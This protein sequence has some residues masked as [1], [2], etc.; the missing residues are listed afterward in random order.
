MLTNKKIERALTKGYGI[1]NVHTMCL[2]CNC[3]KGNK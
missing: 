2:V 1:D 3:E